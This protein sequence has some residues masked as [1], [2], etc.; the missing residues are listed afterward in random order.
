MCKKCYTFFIL[1]CCV[2][3]HRIYFAAARD[4]LFPGIIALVSEKYL[5]PWMSIWTSV[6]CYVIIWS[7]EFCLNVEVP[8]SLDVNMDV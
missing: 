2:L 7:S 4:G 3:W 5:T 8:D 6:S 1:E